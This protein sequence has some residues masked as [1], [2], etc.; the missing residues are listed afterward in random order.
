MVIPDILAIQVSLDI[1][2]TQA[3]AL[4]DTLDIVVVETLD[5]VVI[6]E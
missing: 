3:L 2:V 1:P 6:V 4:V 5:T